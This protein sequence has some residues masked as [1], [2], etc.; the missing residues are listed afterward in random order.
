MTS[1]RVADPDEHLANGW[2][3]ELPSDDSLLRA[4]T[5]AF[6]DM[7]ADVA[8]AAGGRVREEDDVVLADA[9]TPSAY[10]NAAVLRAP[11]RES[12]AGRARTRVRRGDDVARDPRR[13]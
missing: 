2:E 1:D 10:T 4:Y 13:R 3:R 5:D 9:G 8:R 7:V 11:L 12:T 6:A